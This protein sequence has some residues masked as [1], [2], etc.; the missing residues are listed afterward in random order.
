[1]IIA[2]WLVTGVQREIVLFN[3]NLPIRC[4]K[5]SLRAFVSWIRM[6][7][8]YSIGAPIGAGQISREKHYHPLKVTAIMGP[9]GK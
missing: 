6:L 5:T 7:C 4:H 9:S 8:A 3:G 1:M 2:L